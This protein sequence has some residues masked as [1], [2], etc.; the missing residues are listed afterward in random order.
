[1]HKFPEPFFVRMMYT[2]KGRRGGHEER[3][4]KKFENL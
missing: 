3:T 4:N 2:R 1:M